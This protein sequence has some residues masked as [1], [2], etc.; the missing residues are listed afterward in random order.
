MEITKKSKYF[1]NLIKTII[2][3][4][5]ASNWEEAVE[6]WDI[7]DCKESIDNESECIC[8]K[9]NIKYLFEIKNNKNNKSLRPIGSSCIEKFNRNDLNDLTKVN[10]KMFKLLHAVE[11]NTYITISSEFFSRKLLK[12]LLDEGAFTENKYNKF[13][14]END[15]KFL[16]DMFNKSGKGISSLEKKKIDALIVAAIKPFLKQKLKDK[17]I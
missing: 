15:Y 14:T 3:N 2:S 17:I 16:K 6:E 13:N 12:F 4:S 5:C 11:K 7:V 10:E 8:G 1:E 9:E